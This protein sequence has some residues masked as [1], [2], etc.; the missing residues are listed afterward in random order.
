M[1]LSIARKSNETRTSIGIIIIEARDSCPLTGPDGMI[2][3]NKKMGE[4]LCDDAVG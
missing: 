3:D 2:N 4:K 1:F